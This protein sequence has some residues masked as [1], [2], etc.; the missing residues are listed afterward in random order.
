M[1]WSGPKWLLKKCWGSLLLAD[2]C[3]SVLWDHEEGKY[4]DVIIKKGERVVSVVFFAKVFHLSQCRCR[5]SYS[6]KGCTCPVHGGDSHFR[7]CYEKLKFDLHKLYYC[8]RNGFQCSCQLSGGWENECWGALRNGKLTAY[9]DKHASCEIS[10]CST[11]FLQNLSWAQHQFDL[12][13]FYIERRGEID[14][15]SSDYFESIK[16]EIKMYLMI[17]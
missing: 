2:I 3:K 1:T 4:T 7:W 8:W 17:E 14:H 11:S 15:E 5:K 9:N 10:S 16:K 13:T 6:Q 12:N